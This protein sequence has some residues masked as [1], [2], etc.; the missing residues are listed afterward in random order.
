MDDHHVTMASECQARATRDQGSNDEGP[1][2]IQR[3]DHT[4]PTAIENVRLDLIAA[5]A[6]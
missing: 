4:L 1:R 5:A 6:A 3:T 2:S